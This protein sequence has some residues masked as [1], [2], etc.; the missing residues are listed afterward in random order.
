LPS[1]SDPTVLIVAI[2]V[3]VLCIVAISWLVSRRRRR[4]GTHSIGREESISYFRDFD[5]KGP[6]VQEEDN[7]GRWGGRDG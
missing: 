5:S 2:A 3:G 7:V 1:W 4:T 6:G